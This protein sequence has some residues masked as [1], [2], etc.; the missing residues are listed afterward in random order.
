MQRLRSLGLVTKLTGLSLVMFLLVG[1]IGV[2]FSSHKVSVVVEERLQ[3]IVLMASRMTAEI[4]ED[5]FSGLSYRIDEAGNVTDVVWDAIPSFNSHTLVDEAKKTTGSQFS[6]L[7]WDQARADFFRVTTSI[8][9]ENGRR[10]TDSPLG[11]DHPAR[12]SLLRGETYTGSANLFGEPYAVN[13]I[14]IRNPEG[15]VV[16]V[17]CNFIPE[18]VLRGG[19]RSAELQG[20]AGV[21]IASLLGALLLYLAN[22][23]LLRPLDSLSRVLE[24]IREGDTTVEVPALKRQ[25]E[26]GTFARGFEDWRRSVADT[27]EMSAESTRREAEQSR[28]VRDLSDSLTRL[29]ALDLTA[30]IVSASDDPFPARYEELRQNFNNVV[31]MLAET[32]VMI[33]QIAGSI[34]SGASEFNTIAQDMSNRTETQAA[35]LEETAAALDE[36][37]ASV[38]STAENAANADTQ[39]AENGRQAEESGQVVHRAI[40]A[41]E[42]IEQSSRQ[43]TRITDV[44]DDIAFQTNLL[45]L[46]AGV[47]AARAGEAGK[48]FAVVASEVRSLAQRAS[49]SAR[50]IKRLISQSTEQVEAGSALVHETGSALNRMIE[51]IHSVTTLIADIAASA[52]EQSLGLSEINTGVKQLDEVTQRNAAVVVQSTTSSDA[53]H[54]DAMRLSETLARFTVPATKDTDGRTV[55]REPAPVARTPEGFQPVPIARTGTDGGVQQWEDF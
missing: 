44:I 10:W 53:L 14:P 51:R 27:E 24:R 46:N 50:E 12:A 37:T 16:G 55:Q 18:A 20:V 5:T 39:M 6:I 41:M 13:L 33:R 45:A 47:E 15:A 54:N 25:D 43:I 9:D 22:R 1:G 34:D 23:G 28:V 19:L 48:G 30:A 11:P 7:R 4:T 36:L 35:T 38:Q 3:A 52:R 49:E 31:D 8:L 29:S 26:I 42:Q 17:L 40:T 2:W 32:M 21:A